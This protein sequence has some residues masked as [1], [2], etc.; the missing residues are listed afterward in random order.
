MVGARVFVRSWTEDGPELLCRELHDGRM[1][2]S[3]QASGYV[4]SD[5]MPVGQSLLALTVRRDSALQVSL[6]LTEFS[7]R[8]GG[9]I[10]EAA[11]AEFSTGRGTTWD[12]H[13]CQA[14]RADDRI[15]ATLAGCVLCC[16][17]SGRVLWIRRQPWTAPP[18]S[19]S[20]ANAP[21]W[22]Q[23]HAPPLLRNGR[24]LVA[25]PGVGEVQ[26]L[27]VETGRLLWRAAA[28]SPSVLGCIGARAVVETAGGFEALDVES[29]KSLWR[30]DAGP[31]F[32][33]GLCDPRAGIAYLRRPT[34]EVRGA[35]RRR[36]WST[37]ILK[38]AM[39]GGRRR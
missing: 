17:L 24:A 31:R 28:E 16:D 39:R 33:G 29:G 22:R 21:Y 10:R 1:L 23:R 25:Q 6:M 32:E 5:P 9:T 4:V 15:V 13:A 2:W 38:P 20:Y 27:D 11:L 3:A 30:H 12:R 34:G 8:T 36:R 14:A 19:S 35:D 26:C 37:S 7:L 18:S